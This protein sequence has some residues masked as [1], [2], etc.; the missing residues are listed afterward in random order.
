VWWAA[1]LDGFIGKTLAYTG[2]LTSVGPGV[3][4][5]H[6][7][8]H[9]SGI[10]MRRFSCRNGTKG[11]IANFAIADHM[12]N[13]TS[14]QKPNV[15]LF[16]SRRGKTVTLEHTLF[17]PREQNKPFMTRIRATRTV[18]TDHLEKVTP[19]LK[20]WHA[21]SCLTAQETQEL[22]LGAGIPTTVGITAST[23]KDRKEL[24]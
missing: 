10:P 3:I 20:E 22:I 13:K 24:Q 11:P 7:T 9:Q 17:G 5:L 2:E 21:K 18:W 1:D 8:M 6:T 15:V 14:Q 19:V 4:L 16:E 12:Q 23:P